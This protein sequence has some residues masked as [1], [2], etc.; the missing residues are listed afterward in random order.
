MTKKDGERTRENREKKKEK[1]E[2]IGYSLVT[3]LSCRHIVA[4]LS[5]YCR[6]I[7][8]TLSL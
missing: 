3:V 1:T 6:F 7:V 2:E 4:T 8:D 5:I